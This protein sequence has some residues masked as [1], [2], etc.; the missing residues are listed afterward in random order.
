MRTNDG[1]ESRRPRSKALTLFD[2]LE[3]T[4]M[5]QQDAILLLGSASFLFSLVKRGFLK[6]Y[7]DDDP[8]YLTCIRGR[9]PRCQWIKKGDIEYIREARGL[10]NAIRLVELHGYEVRLP[11]TLA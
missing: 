10:C 6:K 11:R 1:R 5:R 7:L 3:N 8:L 2:A 4:P 9:S